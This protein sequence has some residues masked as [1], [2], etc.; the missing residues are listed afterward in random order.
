[1][2]VICREKKLLFLLNPRTGSSALG[3]HLIKEFGGEWLPKENYY[4][5][6]LKKTI[7]FKHNTL[8][9]LLQAGLLKQ[10]EVDNLIVFTG[11]AN[12]YDSL[13]TLYNK[14]RYRYD[15]W[16]KEGRPFLQ[17]HRVASEIAYCK[18]NSINKW[19]FRNYFKASLYALFNLKSYTINE[20]YNI[21]C[22]YIL[23]KENMQEDFSMMLKKFG[24]DGNPKIPILNKTERKGESSKDFSFLSR[25][26]IYITFKNDFK[27]FSYSF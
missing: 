9:E 15:E 19:I 6:K 27:A 17:N 1:M 11:V 4:D 22:N 12:P 5:E 24:V 16:R 25:V 20:G 10:D 3:D 8:E 23:K 13:V 21:G 2:A 18:A 26:L 7:Y 14:Y